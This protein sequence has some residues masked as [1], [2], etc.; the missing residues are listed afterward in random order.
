MNINLACGSVYIT[1]ADWLNLDYVSSGPEVQRADLLRHLP[2][3]DASADLVYSSHFLEHI[4]RQYVA[5]FLQ[6]CWRILKPGGVLRLVVPDLEN[7]CRTYLNYRDLGEHDKADFI[8]LELLDQCV[9]HQ[10]GG[11]LGRYYRRLQSDSTFDSD[12]MAFVRGRTGEILMKSH[13]PRTRG[14]FRQ[15]LRR[16][17]ALAERL[18]IL[19]V[20]Q[21]LPTAFREQN[22][23]LA[24]V[25]ERHQWLY[26]AYSLEQLLRSS[27]FVAIDRCTASVSRHPDFPFHPL[28]LASDGQPRK[29]SESLFIEAQKP[30]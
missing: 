12:V 11:A 13:S 18:W 8:V 1:D 28:D 20:I 27:G 26:D 17:P 24:S 9:R 7:L 4:P 29:G 10:S 3:E 25:G 14:S 22:V 6:E 19:C 2:L 23:S 21:L 30:C 15:I 16:L 5:S